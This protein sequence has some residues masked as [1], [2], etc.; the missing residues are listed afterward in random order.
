MNLLSIRLK[1]CFVSV[2]VVFATGVNSPANRASSAETVKPS[3]TAPEYRQFDFWAGDWDVFEMDNPAK[4]VA[5]AQVDRILDGC[6]LHEDYQGTNGAKGESFSMY[7]ASRKVWHQSWV[8]NRGQ[9]VVI[10]GSNQASAMVLSGAD[11]SPSGGEKQV[12]GTWKPVD[13]GVRETAVTST[14]GG[15]TWTL[16]FDLMF[17]PHTP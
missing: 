4:V 14:D 11:H 1:A 17:R 16:W 15:K 3:C 12:R 5:R 2:V 6:A 13:E 7:D 8:S 9:L 10:E